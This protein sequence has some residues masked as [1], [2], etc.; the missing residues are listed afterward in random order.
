MVAPV[1][2]FVVVV[3]ILIF[4]HE[5]GH[6]LVA[7]WCGVG[8]DRFSLGFG[9]V[10]FSFRRG[11]TEYCLSAIPLGGY[12]KM[13]G[14]ESPLEG[15]GTGSPDSEKSFSEKPVW[16]R[17]LIVFAG[18]GMNFFLPIVLTAG[19]FMAL[20]RPGSPP[21]V[22]PVEPGSPAAQAGLRTGD[23]V[24]SVDGQPIVQ[25]EEMLE[26]FQST[27]GGEI[28]LALRRGEEEIG[29]RVIPR[30]KKLRDPLG[31]ERSLWEIGAR[32]YAPP[33]IGQVM[34]GQPADRAGL[35]AGDT[36]L[37]IDGQPVYGWDELAE[38]IQKRAGKPT[39]FTL[40][41]DGKRLEISVVPEP[42][43]HPGGE[44]KEVGLIGIG[45]SGRGPNAVYSR[46]NP[47]AAIQLAVVW[48]GDVTWLTLRSI[49]KLIRGAI[50]ASNIGSPIM[51][52]VE[53][54]QQARLGWDNLILFTALISVNLGVLNLFPIPVLDGGHLL[55]FAIE[56]IRGRPLSLRKREVAQQVGMFLLL[57]LMVF[58][59]YNDVSR[60][61][62]LRF[63]R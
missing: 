59:V 57:L 50:P 56:A 12:V 33:R 19:L 63:L 37:A 35:R 16:R 51:I 52:A 13:M 25:W 23:R 21:V 22:G 42:G 54:G 11:E 58:A 27:G 34:P 62:L 46:S 14:E 26:R 15:G 28:Q 48:T 61:N 49:W 5:L 38:G 31:D 40:E 47:L 18:P 44:D 17:F 6:F 36:V 1:V 24:V 45:S 2:S 55:F 32:A 20:G 41:R 10:L 43:K 7:R 9:P 53:A 30:Q 29:V 39:I 4:V 60:F 3:G 8:V